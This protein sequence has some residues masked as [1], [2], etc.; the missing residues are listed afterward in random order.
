MLSEIKNV[1][2]MLFT[3]IFLGQKSKEEAM[4]IEHIVRKL[5]HEINGKNRNDSIETLEEILSESVED[6]SKNQNFFHLPLSNI[7]SIISRIN[8]NSLDENDDILGILHN[9]ISNTVKAH[10]T[11]K[12]TLLLLHSIG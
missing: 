6:F 12:E 1:I 3:K 11:E 4:R 9:I 7:F 8:F 2:S 5:V 10:S